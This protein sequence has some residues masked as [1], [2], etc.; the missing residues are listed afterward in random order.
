MRKHVERASHDLKYVITTYEGKHNHEVPAARSSSHLNSAAGG[1]PPAS[2]NTQATLT[3]PRSTT[4]PKAEPHVQDLVPRFERKSEFS[5]E[6]F[7]PSNLGGFSTDMKFGPS[8]CYNM[9][10]PAFHTSVP[11]G[12][13]GSN[14]TH[15]V[16]QQA[17]HLAQ[18]PDFPMAIP[19]NVPMSANLAL[20][21]FG[22]NNLG[23]GA[24]PQTFI[25]GQ[26]A[27]DADVRFVRPKQEK[28]DGGF[29][30]HLPVNQLPNASAGMYQQMMGGYP[31]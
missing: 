11:Y 30:S 19:M 12:S 17:A 3:L 21:G 5:N 7:R 13:F 10:L 2:S 31:L 28:D 23:K 25:S 22:C 14:S 18:V 1:A 9:K 29:E 6:F 26:Q 27:K 24:G 15:N 20:S 8:A 4:I 16:T